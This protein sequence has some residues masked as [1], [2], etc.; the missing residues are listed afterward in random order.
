MIAGGYGPRVGD[1]DRA[2]IVAGAAC[3]ADA[4]RDF[5][6]KTV[7]GRCPEFGKVADA[8]TAVAAGPTDRLCVTR[9]PQ[10]NGASD[11]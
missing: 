1:A 8:R 9:I 11:Q 2:A 4:R 7:T 10:M 3:A 5:S 6:G